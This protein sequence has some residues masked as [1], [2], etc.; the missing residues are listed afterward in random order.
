MPKSADIN[1]LVNEHINT[2]CP[3][4]SIPMT[5]P[6]TFHKPV[7]GELERDVMS[8]QAAEHILKT[9]KLCPFDRTPVSEIYAAPL[10]KALIACEVDMLLIQEN[11]DSKNLTLSEQERNQV[12]LAKSVINLVKQDNFRELNVIQNALRAHAF[13]AEITNVDFSALGRLISAYSFHHH[14]NDINVADDIET[15]LNQGREDT[16]EKAFDYMD[17]QVLK[18]YVNKRQLNFTD[19]KQQVIR[20][21]Q[22]Q[23]YNSLII[24]YSENF[25]KELL[26]KLR[27]ETMAYG[28]MHAGK[29]RALGQEQGGMSENIIRHAEVL[30]LAR[31]YEPQKNAANTSTPPKVEEAHTPTFSDSDH[32]ESKHNQN[33][34]KRV[35]NSQVDR[36]ESIHSQNNNRQASTNNQFTQDNRRNSRPAQARMGRPHPLF[37]LF[38]AYDYFRLAFR[39]PWPS[40][41]SDQVEPEQVT[42]STSPTIR[43]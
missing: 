25:S 15:E 36:K 30:D 16:L 12:A 43:K 29:I 24:A 11:E 39:G 33:K 4:L 26:G 32:K 2:I 21:Q 27:L 42:Q 28:V 31:L 19:V 23:T 17:E 34:N 22:K 40:R 5:D 38:P 35:V 7:D 1:N 14:M 18:L 9:N 13:V 37:Q 8:R 3:I 10:T 6:V 41:R 20:E